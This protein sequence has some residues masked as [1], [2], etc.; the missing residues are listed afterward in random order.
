MSRDEIE[1]HFMHLL[2]I[3]NRRE[4]DILI[5]LDRLNETIKES[6][7]NGSI[8]TNAIGLLHDLNDIS[9]PYFKEYIRL[10]TKF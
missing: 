6:I 2:G 9:G 1:M 3:K 7:V 4:I 10:K 5:S 8:S